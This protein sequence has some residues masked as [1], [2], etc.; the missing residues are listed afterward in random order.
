MFPASLVTC[1]NPALANIH[2]EPLLALFQVE[3]LPSDSAADPTLLLS[4][5]DPQLPVSVL[6]EV[7]P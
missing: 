5:I 1:R 6:Y 3:T 4:V 7:Q 2:G